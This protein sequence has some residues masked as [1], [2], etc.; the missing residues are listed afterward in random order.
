[1]SAFRAFSLPFAFVLAITF[2]GISAAMGQPSDAVAASTSK[3]DRKADRKAR[4]AKKNAELKALQQ[5]NYQGIGDPQR[6]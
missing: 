5:H 3:S 1:M 4:R 2:C 6:K